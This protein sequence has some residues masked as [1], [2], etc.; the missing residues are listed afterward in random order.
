VI[1]PTGER[2]EGSLGASSRLAALRELE[3]EGWTPVRVVEEKG[4][5][6]KPKAKGKKVAEGKPPAKAEGAVGVDG[7]KVRQRDAGRRAKAAAA[8][9]ARGRGKRVEL[10]VEPLRLKR[11]QL[12]LF[13]EELGDLLEAGLP[14]ES[15]LKL[16]AER[17]QDPGVR[18]VA[19][20]VRA[21]V[22]EGATL[23]V[24][25]R[26][27]S[28]S[29]DDF[30]TNLVAAGESSASLAGTLKRLAAGLTVMGDLQ[31]RV[32]GAMIY[33]AF[34]IVAC[35]ALL[36]VFV[37]VLVPQL[38]S[39]LEQTGQELPPSTALL[40]AL[41]DFVRAW[42][43]LMLALLMAA[44][45]LFRVYVAS[46][47]GSVWWARAQLGLPLFG[48][49]IGMR[50]Q[51]Q[52][53][54]GMAGLVDSGVPL[55]GALKLMARA[56]PNLYVRDALGRLVAHVG[57]GGSMASG[58]RKEGAAFPPILSD[59][60]AV[61]EQTGTLGR[62]LGKAAARFDK[63]LD[64]KIKRLVGLIPMIIIVVMALLVAVIAYSIV[65]AIFQSVSG[66]G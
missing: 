26:K 47:A 29:F 45:V 32:L 44:V 54:H 66:I 53:A 49:V 52:L 40:V 9:S 7:G 38:T 18:T 64:I 11:R 63:E 21:Q 31:T 55:I 8:G 51:A 25:L 27:A 33:P 19:A 24:A 39:L 23:T 37:T 12:I 65:T 41:S 2:K 50:N 60:V 13:T 5:E 20:R 42:W 14:L 56:I 62:S 16:L 6:A 34:M 15:G 43:W 46:P 61:G 4:V 10:G 28:P 3:R 17:Q 22:R 36:V 58:L 1:T 57:D 35:V 30:Y 59:M 48:G